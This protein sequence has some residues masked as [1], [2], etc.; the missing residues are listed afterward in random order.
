MGGLTEFL[1]K[2]YNGMKERV[3]KAIAKAI[4]GGLGTNDPATIAAIE[5]GVAYVL[6]RIW[7]WLRSTW[8]D[9]IFKPITEQCTITSL[10]DLFSNGQKVL[11][12]GNSSFGYNGTYQLNFEWRLFS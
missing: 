3:T 7:E 10:N 12:G 5:V 6:D 2:V 9:D 11:L 4:A 1:D 8:S